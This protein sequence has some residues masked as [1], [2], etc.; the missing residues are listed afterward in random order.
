M[1]NMCG[2]CC[3]QC[4]CWHG[5]GPFFGRLL[6]SL[7]FIIAGISKFVDLNSAADSLRHMNI[8]GATAYA[9]IGGLMEIVGGLMVLLGFYTRIGCWILMVFLFVTTLIFH[10]FWNYEGMNA[11]IQAIQFLKNL[12]TFGGLLL[13]CS[14]GPGYWSFDACCSKRCTVCCGHHKNGPC[15]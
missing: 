5:P 7:I 4:R 9:I 1:K 11:Q 13:L 3:G 15:Q 14:Y 10:G 2:C 8:S 6:L 12:T